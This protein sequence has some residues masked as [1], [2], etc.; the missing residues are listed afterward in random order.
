[1]NKFPEGIPFW[2]WA[3][4]GDNIRFKPSFWRW[5]FGERIGSLIL[6]AWGLVPFSF[7]LVSKYKKTY[8]NHFFFAGAVVYVTIIASANV[9]HDY[10]QTIIIPAIALVLAQG[11]VH[12]WNNKLYSTWIV[13]SLLVLSLVVMFFTGAVKVR[14]F[15]KIN[16]P[17]IIKAGVVVD[18]N[19]PKD[20]LVIAPYNGDT[21]FLYQTRRAG[22][23]FMDRPIENLIE[24]GAGYYISVNYD[25]VTREIMN[26]YSVEKQTDDFVIVKLNTSE[27]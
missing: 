1:M 27:E 8:F 20:A 5:I 15:Y 14:E 25:E 22:W 13:R 3:F 9:M 19:I 10:Y 26:K 4:N 2:K 18:S 16:H 17:E 7:G 24:E 11:T 12:M 6:G 23:P 21:A